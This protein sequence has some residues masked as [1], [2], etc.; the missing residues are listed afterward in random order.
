MDWQLVVVT[1][2]W[3]WVVGAVLVAAMWWGVMLSRPRVGVRARR[4]TRWLQGFAL[5]VA[6]FAAATDY[7]EDRLTVIP[8]AM[9]TASR[10]VGALLTVTGV[11]SYGFLCGW[12]R[13]WLP[14]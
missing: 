13:W 2:F 8:E 14:R 10:L 5:L 11:Y 4:P 6:A 3:W 7:R 1:A 12:P 9:A